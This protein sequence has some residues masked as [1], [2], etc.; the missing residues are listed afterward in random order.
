MIDGANDRA[1]QR[2]AKVAEAND[3]QV[4]AYEMAMQEDDGAA[5][6]L[7]GAVVGRWYIKG[8][9][10]NQERRYWLYELH[11]TK[12]GLSKHLAG[13]KVVRLIREARL[14][15]APVIMPNTPWRDAA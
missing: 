6:S 15:G 9:R 13:Y 5:L 2:A 4:L 1:T 3:K 12:S 11:D 7:V 14:N 10:R 8:R